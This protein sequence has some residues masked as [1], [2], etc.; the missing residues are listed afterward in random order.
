VESPRVIEQRRRRWRWNAA[1]FA[2][3]ACVLF[4]IA[5]MYYWNNGPDGDPDRA[6]FIS[7]AR[8]LTSVAAI[9]LVVAA[10]S[11]WRWFAASHDPSNRRPI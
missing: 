3:F 11:T 5:R 4:A 9:A 1:C 8:F 10:L 2:C 7:T 6:D